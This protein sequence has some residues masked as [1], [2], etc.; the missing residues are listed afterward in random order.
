MINLKKI[1]CLLSILTVTALAAK[2]DFASAGSSSNL[3]VKFTGINN[4]KGQ[5][6]VNLFNGQK[7]FP[8]GGKGSAL[9]VARCTPVVK[10][11]AQITF[12]NLPYG[13]YAIAAIHDTN[14]DTRLNNN[15]FG[16][17]TEGVGF[18]NNVIVK[19]SAPSFNESQ[20]SLSKPKADLSIKVQYF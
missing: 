19:T 5:M 9:K 7:G 13:N 12:A 11:N 3:T 2:V 20:F 6:C 4:S 8:D 1:A 10:G 17:P 14:G 18:S 15:F 16:V